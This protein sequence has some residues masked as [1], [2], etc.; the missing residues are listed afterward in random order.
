MLSICYPKKRLIEIDNPDL[1]PL[2]FLFHHS[3][4]SHLFFVTRY[5]PTRRILIECEDIYEIAQ[6]ILLFMH[7]SFARFPPET[8]TPDMMSAFRRNEAIWM[9]HLSVKRKS[10]SFDMP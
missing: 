7:A 9:T 1:R 10:K 3:F 8:I 6:R 5:E 4:Q 2:V